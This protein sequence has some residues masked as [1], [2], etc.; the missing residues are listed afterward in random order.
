[1]PELPEIETIC[2]GIAS[3]LKN[4]KVTEVIINQPKLRWP[5]PKIIQAKL[6]NAKILNIS[7]RSKYIILSTDKGS[8]II[9]LGMSGQLLVLP[10]VHPSIKH[11]HVIINLECGK[12][13]SFVD[14]RRFGCI[15][16]TEDD[17]SKHK[18]LKT[19]GPEPL[20]KEFTGE[21]IIAKARTKKVAIKQFLMD[22][23]IVCGIGNIYANEAMFL[24]KIHPKT[25]V[26]LINLSKAKILVK[27]IQQ[28]LTRAIKHGGTTLRDYRNS[29]GKKGNFKEKLKIYG[30][31]NEPCII[32]QSTI[33]HIR[34]N[35]RSTYYCPKCQT[36]S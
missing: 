16:W 36:P 15:L 21:Y 13:L 18:L 9:H 11:E 20:A 24:A 32:C 5:V 3:S 33:Q 1:M 6:K 34:Q 35:Q 29:E 12:A 17:V 23:H 14:P 7:R 2:R 22:S 31:K 19:L 28:V 4:Q 30:R 27:K 10:K 8:L 26:N 25:P